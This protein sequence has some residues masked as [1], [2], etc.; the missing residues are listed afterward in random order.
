[1]DLDGLLFDEKKDCS[2]YFQ[3]Y[4]VIRN[5]IDKIIKKNNQSKNFSGN[6]EVLNKTYILINDSNYQ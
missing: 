2:D 4:K 5:E 3:N 1:L 6:E